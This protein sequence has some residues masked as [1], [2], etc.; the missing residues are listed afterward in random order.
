MQTIITTDSKLD[1]PGFYNIYPI[2]NE[3]GIHSVLAESKKSGDSINILIDDNYGRVL[4]KNVDCQYGISK[5]IS[6]YINNSSHTI[7]DE[8]RVPFRKIPV[9]RFEDNEKLSNLI[10]Q[11]ANENPDH[12]ILLRGQTSLYTIERTLEENLFLFGDVKAKEPSFK[13]S[14]IRSD[15]NEFFIYGLWHSQTALMLNDVGIDLK[16][17]LKAADYEE[18]RKDVF[19]IKNSPHF[20]PISLGFAQHYGLPSVGLDLTK[21]INVATWFATNKLMIDKDGLAYTRRIDDFSEST[22][23]IFRCQKDVVFSHKSIKPK[24]IENTRPDRQD[25]W[26]CHTGWGFSKNQLASNLVCAI[27]LNEQASDLSN[28]D[29]T[30]FLFP[31]RNEDLVLNYFLDIKENLKNTGE[32]K[33]ALSKIYLLNDK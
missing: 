31:D 33:R 28:N 27:R 11:I 5:D 3:F 32:L 10:S 4:N 23:F 12:E 13:P 17:K 25:A 20:T 8:F 18:Y 2:Q 6:Y 16:K 9:Y 30:S 26:F 19:K 29:Y 7:I 15:F 24:F 1:Y 21:D 22:I 14:F